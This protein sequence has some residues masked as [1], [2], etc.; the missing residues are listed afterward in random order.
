M[1]QTSEDFIAVTP[2]DSLN[3]MYTQWFGYGML[4]DIPGRPHTENLQNNKQTAP[5]KIGHMTSNL[6][7]VRLR[8]ELIPYVYSLA[9]RANRTGEAVMPPL[10]YYF[11]N[12]V[13]VRSMGHEKMIG[14]WLLAAPA[15]KA[16]QNATRCLSACRNL[17]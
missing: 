5:D 15:A 8:Y 9:H 17:V 2:Q 6:A 4:F 16:A 12:D 11:Q 1:V 7:N 10:V 3:D 13:N 14:E